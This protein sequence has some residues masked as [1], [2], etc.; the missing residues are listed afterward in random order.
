MTD[1]LKELSEYVDAFEITDPILNDLAPEGTPHG[2]IIGQAST[3]TQKMYLACQKRFETE[4]AHTMIAMGKALLELTGVDRQFAQETH[5]YQ[6]ERYK[7]EL[8]I[9]QEVIFHLLNLQF[10]LRC[11]RLIL[12]KNFDIY[13]TSLCDKEHTKEMETSSITTFNFFKE[14]ME[15]RDSIH[16]CDAAVQEHEPDDVA[17][18]E[19]TFVCV[20]SNCAK[21][22]KVLAEKY[23]KEVIISHHEAEIASLRNIGEDEGVKLKNK[24]R[25]M[26]EKQSIIQ[27]IF[28]EQCHRENP[29]MKANNLGLRKGW[30]LVS[31]KTGSPSFDDFLNGFLGDIFG[32]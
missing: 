29:L 1:F 27:K 4:A 24:I 16:L 22:T 15:E 9:F 2:E 14:I 18:E 8:Q 3:H 7:A 23:R 13:S 6:T 11:G 19:E 12:G 31:Y 30:K 28:W 17:K 10:P 5:L 20:L 32:S 21:R 25:E 26:R